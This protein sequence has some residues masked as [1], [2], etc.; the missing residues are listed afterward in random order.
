MTEKSH[1]LLH[2]FDIF[3]SLTQANRVS[4]EEGISIEK[5]LSLD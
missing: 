2:L 3:V 1:L 4:W 5:M